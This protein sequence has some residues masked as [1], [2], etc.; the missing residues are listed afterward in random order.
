MNILVDLPSDSIGRSI[1]LGERV[2]KLILKTVKE[3]WDEASSAGDLNSSYAEVRITDIL[4]TYMRKV[5]NRRECSGQRTMVVFPGTESSPRSD[6]GQ[7]VG[8][9]DISLFFC[10]VFQEKGIHDPHA[11]IECKRVSGQYPHLC[12]LYVVEGINRFK[13]GKYGRSHDL[14][15]MVGYLL[16]EDPSTA[17]NGINAYLRKKLRSSEALTMSHII[18]EDWAWYS[19]HERRRNMS[20][21]KIHHAYLRLDLENDIGTQ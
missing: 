13:I 12:R 5:L 2:A 1:R 17:V 14:G 18:T 20:S 3:A 8:I 16:S 9:T 7:G 4:R 11:V 21:I 15:F 6:S 19:L 10:S